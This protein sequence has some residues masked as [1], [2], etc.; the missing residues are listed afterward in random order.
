M[1]SNDFY[2]NRVVCKKVWKNNAEWDRAHMTIWRMRIA[3]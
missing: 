1:S 2:K 3:C